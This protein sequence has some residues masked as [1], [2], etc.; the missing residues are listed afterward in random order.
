MGWRSVVISQPAYLSLDKRQLSIE[1]AAGGQAHIPLEDLSALILDCPRL[2]LSQPLLCQLA[3][4]GIM[5]LTVNDQHLPNGIFLPYQSHYLGLNRLRAQLALSRP[6]AKQWQQQIIRQKILNQKNTLAALGKSKACTAL[7]RM[8]HGIRSGDPDNTEAQAAALYFRYLFYPAL[9][10][11]QPRFYN[12][13]LN[14]GYAVI[15]A[16]IARSIAGAGLQPA[17]GLFHDN[18]RNPF[19]LADDLIEPYR[20]LLDLWLTRRFTKEPER[21]LLPAD[22]GKLVNF[23]HQDI[24]NNQDENLCTVLAHIER[25]VQSIASAMVNGGPQTLWLATQPPSGFRP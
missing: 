5:V 4:T 13:A 8:V 2:T 9:I 15:R 21:E 24:G 18:E 17:L 22:K 1:L 25:M 16:A 3:D 10:R 20:P 6:R 14:Y 11:G 12:A 19:N 7:E 23:L